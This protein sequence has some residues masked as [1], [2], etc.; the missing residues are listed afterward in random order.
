MTYDEYNAT[1]AELAVVPDYLTNPDWAVW[2]PTMIAM[3]EGRMYRELNLL[4]ANTVLESSAVGGNRE[5]TL[6]ASINIVESAFVITPA[7]T[8][9]N[10]GNRH[11][12][13]RVSLEYMSYVWPQAALTGVPT[14]FAMKSDT[15]AALAPTPDAAY[16]V[17]F[18]G[19]STPAPLSASNTTTWLTLNLPDVFVACS[20]IY[21]FANQRDWGASSDDPQAAMSW[22]QSYKAMMGSALVNEARRNA[23]GPAWQGFQPTPIAQPART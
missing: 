18:S 4:Y 20:A 1:M 17:E 2:L 9:A 8:S 10:A 22:E 23:E 5:V 19:Q 11:A 3:A 15:V 16:N 13:Q 6:P 12:L 14:W 7:A 21:S